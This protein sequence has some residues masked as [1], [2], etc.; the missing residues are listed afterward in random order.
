MIDLE[1]LFGSQE[2]PGQDVEFRVFP[3]TGTERWMLETKFSRPW[4]LETWP[5]A[6]FRAHAIYLTAR[7]MG[8]FRLQ[9]PSR[10]ITVTIASNSAYA[11]FRER[12]DAL[13]VFLGTPGPNRKFV[14]FAKDDGKAWFIKVP[15]S[16]QSAALAQTEAQA[17]TDL[18][19]DKT[20]ADFVPRH[21]WIGKS[22]VLE[23][24]ATGG[25]TYARLDDDEIVRIHELLFVR[26][27]MTKVLK[28][29]ARTWTERDRQTTPHSDPEAHA[30][31]DKARHAARSYLDTLDQ[32]RL[33]ECYMAHGDFTRWNVLRAKDGS[34]RVIDWEMFALRPK[35]FDLF[36]YLVSYAILV[37]RATPTAI[38]ERIVHFTKDHLDDGNV[39]AYFG[40]YLTNQTLECCNIFERQP[41]LFVQAYWQLRTFTE[42]LTHLTSIDKMGTGVSGS[43]LTQTRKV[44]V[45]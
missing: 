21:F 27:R 7:I 9:L 11:V 43:A 30:L 36:H 14:V 42:L 16:T 44:D 38:L 39:S 40:L 18:K 13:G 45:S 12:F 5:R 3:R 41:L 23:D 26:S 17:L 31:I 25:T 33:V 28:G 34:A 24:I 19:E 1:P 10:R 20:V 4:H 32:D 2:L 22:L 15:T 37:D 35:Y 8:V 29:L 6:N